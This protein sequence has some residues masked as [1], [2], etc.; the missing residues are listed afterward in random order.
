MMYMTDTLQ[1]YLTSR[2]TDSSSRQVS[3]IALK[4]LNVNINPTPGLVRMPM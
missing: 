3:V 2:H 1:F 4:R